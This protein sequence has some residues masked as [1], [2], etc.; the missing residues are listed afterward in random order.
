MKKFVIWSF[1]RAAWWLPNEMGY[2]DSL[3][4]AGKYSYMDA[5]R[6]AE[7]S[8]LGN[9]IMLPVGVATNM[10]PPTVPSLWPPWPP[11]GMKQWDRKQ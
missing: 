5:C 10:G 7:R 8:E 11:K 6:I 4:R 2:T 1:S 9:S 3:E